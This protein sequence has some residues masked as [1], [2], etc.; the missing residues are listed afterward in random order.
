MASIL[1][2]L[3]D[4]RLP[5][6]APA[7]PPVAV[8]DVSASVG[9]GPLAPP[10]GVRIAP[11]WVA[12]GTSVRR[13]EDRS[14]APGL[15]REGTRLA[16]GMRLAASQGPGTDLWV[17][18]DGRATG[19]DPTEAAAAV[20]AAG[21]RVWVSAPAGPA[22]DVAL[23][24]ARARRP[25]GGGTEV[26]VT[27]ASSASGSARLVLVREG[28]VID[29]QRV[30]LEVGARQ[31]VVLTDAGSPRKG[32]AYVVQ[33]EPG[34]GT[35][36]DDPANDRLAL[37]VPPDRPAVLVWGDLA[38]GA[39]TEPGLPFLVRHMAAYEEGALEAADC[40]VLASMPWARIRDEGVRDLVR[41]VA[42]GGRVLILGGPRSWRAGGWSGTA[43]EDDLSGLRVPRPEGPGLALL[44]AVD[45]SGSTARGALAHLRRAVRKV[46]EAL[47]PGERLAVLPFVERPAPA[48]LP[49]GWIDADASEGARSTLDQRIE[50]LVSGGGT[51]L[52]AALLAGARWASETGARSKR[53]LLLTDG[54]PDH[55]P[56]EAALAE[57][58]ETFQRLDVEVLALVSGMPEAA[59]RLRKN[60][61]GNPDDVVLLDEAA[62]IPE[63]ILHE[64]AR[65]RGEEE[66]LP[67]PA[68][69]RWAEALP[70][71]ASDLEP[72]VVQ[73]LETCEAGELLAE[74]FWSP[75][76]PGP[77]PFAARRVIGAGE[78]LSL[79]WG[80]EW[81]ADPQGAGRALTPL[82]AALAAAADRGLA[83]DVR[84]DELVLRVPGA[85]GAGRLVVEDGDGR[86][87]LLEVERGLFRGRVPGGP[88]PGLVVRLPA[89]PGRP[90]TLRPL[91]LP[92]RPT[93]EHRGAG[94]DEAALRELARAGGGARLAAGA[95]PPIPSRPVGE[96]LAPW[97]LVLALALFLVDRSGTEDGARDGRSMGAGGSS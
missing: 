41:F 80:P 82:V 87:T 48:L 21:G 19:E 8:V 84:G 67:A 65:L 89:R 68:G 79:A 13:V 3:G 20:R 30:T 62:A 56:G 43:L 22:A 54:D 45:T 59:E 37:G 71:L 70:G 76:G 47:R 88:E 32:A 14:A 50:G 97:L 52:A 92:A 9:R 29:Q 11:A 49:P 63:R 66:R 26:L 60:L 53:V 83:A 25:L 28:R 36:N 91:R 10:E 7:P 77:V 23:L 15:G 81:E 74:A 96:P 75:G 95:S 33:L 2:A 64:I 72:S 16:E 85:A 18:T 55:P 38:V 40:V 5:R 78:T 34:R 46:V 35:P 51:D 4:L 58:R 27:V 24:A 69:V 61:A 39:W 86:S 6:S 12:V 42:G 73:A 44:V 57:V 90:A 31:D 17:F 93:A 1:G 94:V